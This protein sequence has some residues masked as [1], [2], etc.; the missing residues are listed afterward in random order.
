[1]CFLWAPVVVRFSA[2]CPF[3]VVY[4]F[5]RCSTV[6]KQKRR[7]D[8][9]C[10][11]SNNMKVRVTLWCSFVDLAISIGVEHKY[12]DLLKEVYFCVSCSA[13]SVLRCYSY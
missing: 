7:R 13:Q 1:M 10:V 8:C 4:V 6:R 3:R 2:H 11:D 12:S 9:V 5:V